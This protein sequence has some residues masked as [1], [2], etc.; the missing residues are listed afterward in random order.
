MTVTADMPATVEFD[1][2]EY[3]AALERLRAFR[4]QLDQADQRADA[5]S[6]DRAADLAMIFSDPERRWVKEMDETHPVK[7]THFRGRPVDPEGRSRFASYVNEKIGLYPRYSYFLLNAD[8][9]ARNYLYSVQ[10]IRPDSAGSLR[11]LY[12]L[13]KEERGHEAPDIWQRAVR[14]AGEDVPTAAQVKQ[15]LRDHDKTTGRTPADRTAAYYKRTVKEE[16]DKAVRAAKWVHQ[17]GSEEEKKR[18]L[19]TI[20]DVFTSTPESKE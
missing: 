2:V 17:Y 11:P 9:I 4:R 6:L 10:T 18:L 16:L 8:E 13:L 15:A 7:R 1:E 19:L 12:K 14:L 5:G 20:H 3:E